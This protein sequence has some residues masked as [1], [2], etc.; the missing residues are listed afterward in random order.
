M[1]LPIESN[2]ATDC[3][4]TAIGLAAVAVVAGLCAVWML[5]FAVVRALRG[6]W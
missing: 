1:E 2:S 5:G 4:R 6:E 3:V